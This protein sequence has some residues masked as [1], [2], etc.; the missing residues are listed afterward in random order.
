MNK[1]KLLNLLTILIVAT[2][3][4]GFTSCSKDDDEG[5]KIDSPVVGTWKTAMASGS[6]LTLH[7]RSNATAS[8]I[9]SKN[10]G[11]AVET[12][13]GKYEV[14]SGSNGVIKFYWEDDATPQ[15]WDF[16][17]VNNEMKTKE[18]LSVYSKSVTWTRQ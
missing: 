7:L 5:S 18:T 9:S 4:I 15:F 2:L 10:Y 6:Q 17:I 12:I 13:N 8:F 1:K 16:S 3:S 11:S 14:S